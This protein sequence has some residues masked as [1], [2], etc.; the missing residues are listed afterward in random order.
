MIALCKRLYRQWHRH[1]IWRPA[2]DLRDGR[3]L[4]TLSPTQPT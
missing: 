1:Y 3:A 4:A 2:I